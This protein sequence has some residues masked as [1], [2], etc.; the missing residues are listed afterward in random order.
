[1]LVA[2][3]RRNYWYHPRALNILYSPIECLIRWKELYA[4][5]IDVS[6]CL[7]LNHDRSSIMPSLQ[8]TVPGPRLLTGIVSLVVFSLRLLTEIGIRGTFGFPAGIIYKL[9]YY[10]LIPLE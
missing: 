2:A 9:G 6:D 10:V 4:I 3:I 7:M 1:M 5:C 8:I